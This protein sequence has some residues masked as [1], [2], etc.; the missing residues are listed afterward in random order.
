M[1]GLVTEVLRMG[2]EA[3]A[4]IFHGDW[5]MHIST[6]NIQARHSP[7][8]FDLLRAILV[9]TEVSEVIKTHNAFSSWLLHLRVFLRS[10]RHFKEIFAILCLSS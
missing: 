10:T 5:L 1:G 4:S 6:Q 3:E 8:P 9:A 2:E 7:F